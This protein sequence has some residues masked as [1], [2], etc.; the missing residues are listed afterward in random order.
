MQQVQGLLDKPQTDRQTD[1]A[2]TKSI[3][4][5][6]DV[7][8]LINEQQQKSKNNSSSQTP[9]ADEMAF[10]MQM[11]ALQNNPSQGMAMNPNGGGSLAGGTT[12]RPA[13]PALGDPNA[14]PGDA[15]TI[16]RASGSTANFPTEF[17][18]ALENYFQGLEGLE[19]K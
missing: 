9:T 19:R 1:L 18:E 11:M 3:E 8:N 14:P 5:L 10:L 2:Q 13:I 17:R 7:I 15:R 6:S 12:D 4:L 16:N